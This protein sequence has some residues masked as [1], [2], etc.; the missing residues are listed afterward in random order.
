MA[1]WDINERR[2]LCEGSMPQCRGMPGQG[3]G[4]GWINE[5]GLGRWDRE[6]FREEMRKV[7]NI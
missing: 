5:Q 1:L 2:G 4:A 7:D 6:V 3:C